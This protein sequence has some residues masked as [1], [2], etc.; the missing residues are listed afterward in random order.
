MFLKMPTPFEMGTKVALS[1]EAGG[2]VLPFAQAEVVWRNLEESK[3]PGRGAGFGVR[4]TGFLHPRAHELVDYLVDN[5]GTGKPLVSPEASSI[6][7]RRLAWAAAGLVAVILGAVTTWGVLHLV[8]ESTTEPVPVAEEIVAVAPV[9][10]PEQVVVPVPVLEDAVIEVEPAVAAAAEVIVAPV[11]APSVA[12]ATARAQPAKPEV[13]PAPE[14]S[15]LAIPSGA[16]RSL[17]SSL[18]GSQLS[19][20]LALAPGA[21]ITR[22]FTL[23]SPDRVALDVK[24]PMPKRSYTLAG[25]AEVVR[26]RVGRIPGGTRLVVDLSRPPGKPTVSGASIVIP[27]R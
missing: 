15:G 8:R 19:V 25:S 14:L 11:P 10:S 6:W 16:V 27:L 7:P 2:R 1:L 5:L 23:R 18:D 21:T 20:T 9:K 26:V 3:Q 17:T 13:K 4:F 12:P 24:G 22:A